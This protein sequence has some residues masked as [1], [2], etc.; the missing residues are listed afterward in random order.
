MFLFGDLDTMLHSMA[1]S[2]Q[3]S[4]QNERTEMLPG[5]RQ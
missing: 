2:S 3:A 4:L 1:T 5:L